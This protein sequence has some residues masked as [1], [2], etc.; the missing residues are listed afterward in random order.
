M[1]LKIRVHLNN[2]YPCNLHSSI[3]NRDFRQRMGNVSEEAGLEL[4]QGMI[5]AKR[6][7]EEI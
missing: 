4:K 2:K 7:Q 1:F 5:V 3:D 6:L